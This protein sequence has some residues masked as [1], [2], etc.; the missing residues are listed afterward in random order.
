MNSK[1]EVTKS[2]FC[3]HSKEEIAGMYKVFSKYLCNDE[4][5]EHLDTPEDGPFGGKIKASNKLYRQACMDYGVSLCFFKNFVTWQQFVH[6]EIEETEFYVKAIEEIRK[7]G[8]EGR[9]YN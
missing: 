1:S 9:S 3:E 7:L 6:G 8:D 5:N 2:R 4:K